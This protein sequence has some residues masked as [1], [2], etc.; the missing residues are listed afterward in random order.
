MTACTLDLTRIFSDQT[1]CVF[2]VTMLLLQNGD[3][4]ENYRIRPQNLSTQKYSGRGTES[5]HPRSY[6]YVQ[7]DV[8][9]TVDGGSRGD[10]WFGWSET[11]QSCEPAL[12]KTRAKRSLT[13]A[14]RR[15]HAETGWEVSWK[16]KQVRSSLLP[17]Q[18]KHGAPAAPAAAVLNAPVM[19]GRNKLWMCARPPIARTP[20]VNSTRAL[21]H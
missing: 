18:Q 8:W 17:K 21:T 14:R 1:L 7:S 4:G 19:L 10:F 2:Q 6:L 20:R 5:F 3:R 15:K 16:R 11:L 12:M 13:S 9:F